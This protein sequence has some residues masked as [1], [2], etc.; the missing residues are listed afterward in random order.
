LGIISFIIIEFLE[1]LQ[2]KKEKEIELGYRKNGYQC[3]RN[4]LRKKGLEQI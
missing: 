1:F 4:L 3:G 2:E